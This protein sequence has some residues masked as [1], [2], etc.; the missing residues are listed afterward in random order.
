MR[1]GEGFSKHNL[2]QNQLLIAKDLGFI[3]KEEFKN[4]SELS[5]ETAKLIHGIKKGILAS[6][7]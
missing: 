2:F 4:V 5:V 6:S 3:A 1:E 7:N